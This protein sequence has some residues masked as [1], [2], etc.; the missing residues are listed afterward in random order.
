M[1]L[2][3]VTLYELMGVTK[4][5]ASYLL[6]NSEEEEVAIIISIHLTE[7]LSNGK[8]YHF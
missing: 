8:D 6:L 1:N 3:C 4:I 5:I 7:I 2:N